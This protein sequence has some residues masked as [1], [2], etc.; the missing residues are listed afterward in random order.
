MTFEDLAL[1]PP[2]ARALK[3]SSYETPTAIQGK[4]IPHA[5]NRKDVL[6]CA[7]TGTGKTAA[8]AL[9]ILDAL[10]RQKLRA[11]PHYPCALVLAPTR[12]LA[13]QIQQSFAV[14]GR[15]LQL[16][17]CVIYGGVNQRKQVAALERGVH[18]L[19]ATP[20]RLLDLVNQGHLDLS[21]L[22]FFVLDEAD[23]ML[24]MGFLPAI[25][26]IIAMLPKKRQ[27][28]FFSA[29]LPPKIIQL[30]KDL[31][32]DPVRVDVT[33][34]KASV[35]KIDQQVIHT[36]PGDKKRLLEKILSDESVDRAIVFTRT[37]RGANVV[38][39]TLQEK[40]I[41]AAAIHGNKS[42]NA[43]EQALADFR[44]KKLKVL[45]ATDL[46]S[47][48]I[49]IEGITHVVNYDLPQEPEAY[50]HRVGR[51]GRAGREGVAIA[52]CTADERSDLAAIER[53]IGHK[54]PVAKIES[55]RAVAR[56]TD[57]A[58][59][60]A[61]PAAA[62]ARGAAPAPA[63]APARGAAPRHWRQRSQ[64]EVAERTEQGSTRSRRHRRR[65]KS[66]SASSR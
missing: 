26:R 45:V 47:R 24:D 9:P 16:R 8:F 46:A 15:H 54:L 55:R 13:G 4:T 3:E 2:I 5:L 20:G 28:L 43:R 60:A 56:A 31:L 52:F 27:S 7:Q 48:G 34:K 65:P 18:I 59:A 62:A 61:A 19:I 49:D 25:R 10:G 58:D 40:G 21:K 51:T 1:I 29:T 12:E 35:E 23:R 53:L 50:V 42:Q 6:G 39:R 63:A 14:Y 41:R 36:A 44:S 66:S 30:A 32:H 33:P 38:A 22:S 11:A 37:K 57:N 64:K 17:T